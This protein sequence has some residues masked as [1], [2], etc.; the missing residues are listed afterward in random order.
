[1]GVYVNTAD[2]EKTDESIITPAAGK[3]IHLMFARVANPSGAS[4][5][6][7]IKLGGQVY[8]SVSAGGTTRETKCFT[9]GTD[10]SVLRSCD[11][12][13]EYDIHYEEIS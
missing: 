11:T 2:A 9:G 7:E 10:E 8:T 13:A 6:A 12:N 5:A 1:M 4:K 3:K